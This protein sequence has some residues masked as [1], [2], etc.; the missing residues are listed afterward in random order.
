M[1]FVFGLAVGWLVSWLAMSDMTLSG[2]FA[3][4]YD[5]DCP[6]YIGPLKDEAIARL[7]KRIDKLKGA[8]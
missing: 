4:Y 7:Q 1:L 8:E 5:L 6:E 3:K 2:P